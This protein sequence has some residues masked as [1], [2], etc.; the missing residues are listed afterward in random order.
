MGCTLQDIE[1]VEKDVQQ[2]WRPDE[3]GDA[4]E[5]LESYSMEAYLAYYYCTNCT[6]DWKVEANHKEV[7]KK[8]KE[9]FDVS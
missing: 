9:H 6:Q 2:V 4:D 5:Y 7:W 1:M 8:V 3:D